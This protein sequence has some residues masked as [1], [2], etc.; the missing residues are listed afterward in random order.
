M[1]ILITNVQRILYAH[2]VVARKPKSQKRVHNTFGKKILF[3]TPELKTVVSRNFKACKNRDED[4]KNIGDTN[5]VVDREK[6]LTRIF[7]YAQ[8][9]GFVQG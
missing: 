2:V 8:T 6:W 7:K 9:D 4:I 5:L 3:Q 1:Y